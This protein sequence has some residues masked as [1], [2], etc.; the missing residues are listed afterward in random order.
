MTNTLW[1]LR[2]SAAAEADYRNI[3]RWTTEHFGR[4]QAR[5]YADTLKAT[6]TAL[7]AGPDMVG[8]ANR[9]DIGANIRTLHVA[10]NGRH[11]RH[12]VMFRAE[13]TS[14]QRYINVLR[15]LHDSMDLPQHLPST[16]R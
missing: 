7:S 4:A 15:L 6:L 9:E 10:R 5:A 2:L 1:T 11:G 16:E 8:V 14:G 3:L 12:F 13:E